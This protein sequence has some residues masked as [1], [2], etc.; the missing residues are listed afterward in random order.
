[1]REIVCTVRGRK[2]LFNLFHFFHLI[3]SEV[4]EF[5]L[6]PRAAETCNISELC[7]FDM[8]EQHISKILNLYLRLTLTYGG[9]LLWNLLCS[10][11]PHTEL[12]IIDE[13]H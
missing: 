12:M 5:R 11:G 2:S 3:K 4:M 1:M 10:F 13:E 6:P 8:T 9:N 7:M